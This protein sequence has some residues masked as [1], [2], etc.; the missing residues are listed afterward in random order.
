VEVSDDH[1][2]WVVLSPY[3]VITQILHFIGLFGVKGTCVR[4]GNYQFLN[5]S[6]FSPMGF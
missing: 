4:V 3:M 6:F 1:G 2:F 5:A